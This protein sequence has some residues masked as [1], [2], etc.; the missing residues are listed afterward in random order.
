DRGVGPCKKKEPFSASAYLRQRKSFSVR[1][2]RSS[3]ARSGIFRTPARAFRCQRLMGFRRTSKSLLR[4]RV[5]IVGQS[6]ELTQR[7]QLCSDD[8]DDRAREAIGLKN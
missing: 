7:S 1:K 5:G 4:E 3:I 2:R 8:F 6:A